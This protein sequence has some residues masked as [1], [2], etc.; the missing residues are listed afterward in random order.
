MSTQKKI[1]NYDESK[2]KTLSSLEH[3]RLRSGMYIGRLGDGSN[4]Y[5]GIY[6]LLK[7]VIDNCID[8]Y[9][10]GYG[11]KIIIEIKDNKVT[12]R[13]YGRGIPLGK[14]VECVSKINTGA[15]YNDDVFQFS[16]G[17]NGIGTKAV[18][19]LSSQFTV[20]SYR[21]GKAKI[22][23]F[24]KGILKK[25]A[26]KK[27]DKPD[28]T[29][30]Q[31][32]PDEQIFGK[33]TFNEEFVE[34]RMWHYAY[35]N[36][37]LKIYLNNK[38][39]NSENGL[40]DLLQ[41]EISGD[42]L[43]DIIYYKE[44]K[45]EYAFTHTSEYGDTYF[46]FVNGQHTTDGGS[47]QSAIKEGLLK[48]V[49]EYAQKFFSGTDVREGLVC[50]ISI[51]LK[52]PIFESQTKNKL[53][54]TEIKSDL[55]N[56]IKESLLLILHRNQET[57]NKIVEKIKHNENLRKELQAVRKEARE[58]AKK[59]ALKIP[60]LKDSKFH[61]NENNKYA[62][63]T[64]IFLTEG[65]SASGSMVSCRDVL[66][67]AIFSLRGKP[68]NV[69]GSKKDIIYKN[70]ELFNLMKALGI[71]ND[72]EGLRYNKIII[73]TDSDVDGLHIRNLMLTYFLVFF[74][75]VVIAGHLYI[76]ETPLFRVRNKKETKYCY[77]DEEKEEALNLL[78]KNTEITRF[79]GLGEISPKEFGQFIGKDIRL[80]N[81][82]INHM[83]EVKKSLSFF[84]GK[85]TPER[86]SYIMKNLV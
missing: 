13:D 48:A 49:N 73:A 17:L 45:L 33:Y 12:V 34:K 68:L 24:E 51:K 53:G 9:I 26:T 21:E 65:Q 71:E 63:N 80:L 61:Y 39:F 58:K 37:G 7:E 84:M 29:L 69:Y 59:I 70:E 30:I 42:N 85:N 47:H 18:N 83:S 86:K 5:D 35:L 82:E 3:I 77:N 78:G 23:T 67:Q 50:A 72:I 15:K 81:V 64:M 36:S 31:F 56:K 55:V 38:L 25:E 46:S 40:K 75:P 4:Y 11:K 60:G 54:N 41:S 44:D 32:V 14:L 76:L 43:Y 62:D 19:A 10:M 2:I 16:V 8:E 6:I 27:T 1:H 28:G 57:S 74:E 22:A 52:D 79:K 20:A 66:T